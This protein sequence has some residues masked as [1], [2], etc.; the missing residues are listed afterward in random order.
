LSD[1][2]RTDKCNI[3][4]VTRFATF[5][6]IVPD[7]S[8]FTLSAFKRMGLTIHIDNHYRLAGAIAMTNQQ[9]VVDRIKVTTHLVLYGE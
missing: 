5:F 9:L 7:D 3:P 6:A 4:L 2:K 1:C 8:T